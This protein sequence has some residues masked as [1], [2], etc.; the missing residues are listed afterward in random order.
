MG[1]DTNRNDIPWAEDARDFCMDHQAAGANALG[2]AASWG[3]RAELTAA[4]EFSAGAGVALAIEGN[5]PMSAAA[6][7]LASGFMNPDLQGAASAAAFGGTQHYANEHWGGLCDGVADGINATADGLWAVSQYAE[8]APHPSYVDAK[9][10]YD[11][12]TQS[13]PSFDVPVATEEPVSPSINPAPAD[14]SPQAGGWFDWT[15]IT[16]TDPAP[17]NHGSLLDM[18]SGN[19]SHASVSSER[20][21]SADT[22]SHGFAGLFESPSHDT[23]PSLFANTDTHSASLWSD[24]TDTASTPTSHSFGSLFSSPSESSAGSGW[25]SESSSSHS[26]WGGTSHADSNSS[27]LSHDSISSAS[28][29]DGGM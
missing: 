22:S 16:A 28:S 21:P 25:G 29:M 17:A 19:E 6:G 7:S 20:E 13:A 27:A 15:A 10:G 2:S 1:Q 23:S 14:T 18:S 3:T 24:T 4:G 26:D 12:A 5:E 9:L 8:Q 11:P